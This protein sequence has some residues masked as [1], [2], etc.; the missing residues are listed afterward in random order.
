[1]K[2]AKKHDAEI[3]A[4]NKKVQTGIDE[5]RKKRGIT[6]DQ[7]LKKFQNAK[8]ELEKKQQFERI[9]FAHSYQNK[10]PS[11]LSPKK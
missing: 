4:F 10:A 5:L 2:L 7:L 9:A 1:M 11:K 6:E 8:I 3:T